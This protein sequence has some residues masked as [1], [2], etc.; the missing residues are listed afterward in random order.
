MTRR[1]VLML[2]ALL[3]AA[4]GTGMIVFYVKGIETRVTADQELVSVLV[5]KETIQTGETLKA[6]QDDGRVELV[7]VRRADFVTG[8]LDEAGGSASQSALTTIYAG[9]QLLP[10]M[11]G[12]PTSAN[13]SG[14][15][16]EPGQLAISVTLKDSQRV[17]GFVVPGSQVALYVSTDIPGVKSNDKPEPYTGLLLPRVTVLGVGGSTQPKAKEGE[18]QDTVGAEVVMTLAVDDATAQK[19]IFA[20]RNTD[21]S[22]ALLGENADLKVTKGVELRDV[23]PNAFGGAR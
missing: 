8:A 23:I 4:L 9:Q 11:F 1:T 13:A 15:A 14:L 19:V 12:K 3:I 22:F 7:D 16:L 17:G 6:A 18:S 21:V 2:T 10:Q 20:A 5:A